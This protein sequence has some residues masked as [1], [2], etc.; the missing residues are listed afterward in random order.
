LKARVRLG[1]Y[2]AE[3]LE[4]KARTDVARETIATAE[5]SLA[6]LL[7]SPSAGTAGGHMRGH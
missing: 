5:L 3:H 7:V 1:D 6:Q 2:A 4:A